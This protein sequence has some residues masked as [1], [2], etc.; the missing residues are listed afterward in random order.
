MDD[1][2]PVLDS[3]RN[4]TPPPAMSLAARLLNVFA[5]PGEVFADVKAGGVS[6]GNWLVPALLSALVSVLTAVVIVSHP[7]IQR[8][9]HDLTERQAKG[10]E[11][12]VK[13]GK[14]KQADADRVVALT[15]A[16]TQPGP[17]K[18]LASMA[19]AVAGVARVFWWAFVLW[20]LSRLF[21][22]VRLGYPKVLEVAGLGLMISVLGAIV[23]LLLMLNLP[24]LIATPNLASAI[25]DLDAI[26]KSPLLLGAS[27]VFAFWMIGVLSVGLARLAGV[28]F[29]RAAWLVFAAWLVQES[30]IVLVAG[31]LGQIA[32]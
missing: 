1:P 10:L 17:L 22:K 28:P 15:R 25:S 18:I 8:Q 30:L 2:L 3:P 26:R 13:A 5:V 24:G 14:V 7:A 6:I 19:V 21:L 12:Q 32:L 4:A 16:V 20:L 23:T 31:L 9:M 27:Q 11:Q 29:L